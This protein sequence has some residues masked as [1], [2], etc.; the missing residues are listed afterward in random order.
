MIILHLLYYSSTIQ[1]MLFFFSLCPL[2]L[3]F[4]ISIR[5]LRTPSPLCLKFKNTS[6]ILHCTSPHL[7]FALRLLTWPPFNSVTNVSNFISHFSFVSYQAPFPLH[8]TGQLSQHGFNSVI[9]GEISTITI[10]SPLF[11]T[12]SLCLKS[13]CVVSR[14]S[15]LSLLQC[16]SHSVATIQQHCLK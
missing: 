10:H 1:P 15:L 13:P 7:T 9:G 16:T 14:P 5:Q 8:C 12:N 11:H 3:R 6:Q 2:S 4:K